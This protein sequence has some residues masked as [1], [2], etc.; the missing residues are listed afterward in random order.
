MNE[1]SQPGSWQDAALAGLPHL[2]VAALALLPL[3]TVQ[4]GSTVYPVFLFILP[5]FIVAALALAWRRGW[6]RWSASW[7]V[8][9][10]IVVILLPQRALFAVPLI[11]AGWLYGITRQDQIKGLLIAT[12]LML[13][14]WSPV[15]EFVEPTIHNSIQLGMI[16]LAGATAMAIVRLNNVRIGLWLALNA[17]L[18][19]GLLAA[20][21]RTYWHYLPP[22][23]SEPPTLAAWAGLFAPQLVVGSALV[24]GPLLFWGLREIGKRSG[25][26]GMLGYRLALGGLAL[27]LFGNIGYYWQIS[28]NIGPGTLWFNSVVYLGLFL[29]LAGALWLG[30]AARRSKVPLDLASLALLVLIPS[31]LPLMWMLLV[32]I[33]SGFRI[34]PAGLSVALYD[35]GDIYKY[36]VYAVGLAWLLLGGWLVTRLSAMPPR[37]AA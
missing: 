18:L 36:E 32:P 8:Y 28:T 6:P 35:L 34:L 4:N 23:Y 29:C 20:Y 12:P 3:G 22:E 5:F 31:A 15:L 26:A 11:I 25:R 9:V 19:T 33:W 24:I 13:L 1:I 30:V 14:F 7:Y 37:P 2:L 21:A 17:S 27:N 16:L 10:G